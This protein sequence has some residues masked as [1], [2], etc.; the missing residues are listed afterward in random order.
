MTTLP[1]VSVITVCLNAEKT[2]RRTIESVLE[3]SYS[4]IEYIIVDGGSSDATLNIIKEYNGRITKIISE[5]DTGIGDAFNKGIAVA[6]GEYIQ[7]IN[8]DDVL[9]PRKIEHSV[10]KLKNHP[11]AAFVFG[12]IIKSNEKGESIRIH[13]DPQYAHSLSYVMNRVNHPTMLVQRSL[14][15]RYGVFDPQWRVAMDYDW[16]LRIHKA[17]LKGIYSSDIVV[18]TQAGGISD[19]Q[20]LRA[21][22]ECRDISIH[23]GKNRI[24][25][26]CYYGMRILKHLMMKTVG[27]R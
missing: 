21:F 12:D 16:I 20:R 3:Q 22:R 19:A 1:M 5:K 13:G 26:Y 11:D 25:A 8:A 10:L 27:A 15:T 24:F 14:F 18:H 17:G 2:I 9:H 6:T 4:S 7:F 23:H